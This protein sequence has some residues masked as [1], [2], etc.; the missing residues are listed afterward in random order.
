MA[1]FSYKAKDSKGS[2]IQGSLEAESQPMVVTR[3]Q[4]MGYF[5][6]LI[7][8]ESEKKKKS[9]GLKHFFRRKITTA[10][11]AN[12]N[13]Q[14][15]DLIAAGIPLVKALGV[16]ITQ[17]P[18]DA[19]REIVQQISSDV[20][21]GDT[22]ALSLSRHPR[23]FS[24]LYIAMVRAGEAGGMLDVILQRLA[25]FSEAE[26]E[27]R[28]KIK[29]AL[30]YPVVMVSAGSLAVAVLMTVV[31]PRI[32]GIFTSLQQTL[33]APTL[34]LIAISGFLGKTWW[35]L[36]LGGVLSVMGFINF[37]KTTK[38]RLIVDRTK[39]RLPLLGPLIIKRE[40]SR[41]ARTLGSLLHN[42]VPIL[43]AL[44]IVQEV[45]SNRIVQ[46]EVEKLPPSISQGASI[47]QSL[48]G[49]EL[50][51]PVVVN[52][53]AIGEE[54]GRLDDVLV[55]VAQSYESQVDRSV[56]AITSIMEPL[57]I[58]F[59]GLVVGFIVISMLLPIFSLDPTAGAD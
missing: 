58:L 42:G 20:Q 3:L 46:Q 9:E 54:T 50:F 30:A 18:G 22:F 32:V 31:I 28:G 29:S 10:E 13:R 47:S 14:L 21:G 41:F 45:M 26:E 11:I 40:T 51:P 39:L 6:V 12:F 16:I 7:T 35:I 15:S 25:D 38:G 19:L 53:I 24:K 34:L 8:N 43:V 17:T 37:A 57:I 49:S 5:P 33:P 27:L 59:M 56:K 55:R 48:K 23:Y 1:T 44:E 36:I 2:L 52:M 4:A